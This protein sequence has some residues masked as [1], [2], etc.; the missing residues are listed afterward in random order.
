[1]SA[2]DNEFNGALSIWFTHDWIKWWPRA[3]LGNSGQSWTAAIW[4]KI[5]GWQR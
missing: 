4:R 5:V 3:V 2:S 1:M